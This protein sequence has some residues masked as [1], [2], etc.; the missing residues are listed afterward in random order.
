MSFI[1]KIAAGLYIVSVL[2]FSSWSRASE[3]FH[4]V[5]VTS[6][7]LQSL[8]IVSSPGI[9]FEENG[10]LYFQ[11]EED[12]TLIHS[13]SLELFKG[14]ELPQNVYVE[15]QSALSGYSSLN[16]VIQ[17]TFVEFLDK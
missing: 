1:L 8:A 11:T 13:N 9:I 2:A 3:G 10:A 6:L 17:I 12:C 15:G 4:P 7:S 5:D 14:L 16:S